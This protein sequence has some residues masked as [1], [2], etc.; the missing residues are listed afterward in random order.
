MGPGVAGTQ[1]P[2]PTPPLDAHP[3]AHV[4]KSSVC[5]TS[6]TT[7][8]VSPEPTALAGLGAGTGAP[9]GLGHYK[10]DSTVPLAV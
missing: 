6:H 3:A 10:A 9:A 2:H 8:P 1:V 5:L 4:M 7:H